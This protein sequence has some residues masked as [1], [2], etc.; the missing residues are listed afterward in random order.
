MHRLFD[1]FPLWLPVVAEVDPRLNVADQFR[2]DLQF[3]GV[4]TV[5]DELG[6]LVDE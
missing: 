1:E 2:F 5:V 6:V 3:I 4:G